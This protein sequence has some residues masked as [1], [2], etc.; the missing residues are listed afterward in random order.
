MLESEG[1]LEGMAEAWLS[2]GKQRFFCG[3]PR[4]P[5]TLERAIDSARQSGNYHAERESRTWLA[6]TIRD[7]PVTAGAAAC[8]AERL[9]EAAGSDPWAGASVLQ[10]LSLLYGFAGRF[11]EA[12]T[13]YRRGQSIFTATGAKFD[14]ALCAVDS[15]R[16]ELIAQD[17]AAAERHLREGYEALCAMGERGFCAT[18]VALLAQ[19]AYEQGHFQ[20]GAEADRGN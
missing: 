9:L 1:D 3:D 18:T 8:R 14:G 15:G 6:A 5:E 11:A 13:A 2:V 16:V 4:A 17:Y 7:L 10:Q 19:A 20:P 12:R